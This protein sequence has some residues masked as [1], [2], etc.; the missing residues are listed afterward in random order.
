MSFTPSVEALLLYIIVFAF[1]GV[2]GRLIV[3]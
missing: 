2:S 1:L 3:A